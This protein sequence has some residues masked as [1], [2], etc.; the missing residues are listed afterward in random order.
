MVLFSTDEWLVFSK[1]PH[2]AKGSYGVI[3][4]GRVKG[5]PQGEVVVIKDM[6]NINTRSF[7]DWVKEITIMRYAS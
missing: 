7:N 3:F 1:F 4:K 2:I 6:N 5:R